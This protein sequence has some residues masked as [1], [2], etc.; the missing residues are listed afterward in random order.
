MTAW[1]MRRLLLASLTLTAAGAGAQAQ[2]VAPPSEVGVPG[3]LLTAE[4]IQNF[5]LD[6][7]YDLDDPSPG[8]TYFADT[9]LAFGLV[10][11]TPIQTFALGF[12][13][14]LRALWEAEEDFDLT[15]AS[16]STAT[17][18]YGREWASG[19]IATFLSYRQSDEDSS[20]TLIDDDVTTPGIDDLREIERDVIERRL[21]GGF[22]L[23]IA[24]DSPSSY[25]LSFA[26]S[27][28]D[29]DEEAE[30][31][32]PRTAL[33]G[34]ARWILQLNPL[35]SGVVGA[36]YSYYDAENPE[37]T[38]IREGQVDFG[39]IYTPSDILEVNVGLGYATYKR[40][41]LQDGSRETLD[42]DSGYVLLGGV[43]YLFEDI[44]LNADLRL[45]NAAPETRLSGEVR[46]VYPLPRGLV[47]GRVF[48]RYGG[49][50]TGEEVRVTG[51][52]I[53]LDREINELSALGF[54]L[55]LAK[56]E[57]LDTDEPDVERLEFTAAYSYALT[58]VVTASLGYRFRAR[59]EDP[60]EATGNAVFVEIG[61]T[62]ETRP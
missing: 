36:A 14:G 59:N 40:E 41:E 37:E 27:R 46:A 9:R 55:A 58:E 62:F 47:R 2:P 4:I 33:D 32:T 45:T 51:A 48:Q 28:I 35:I 25:E 56:Q 12:D 21:D 44:T 13:T 3:S 22:G 26:G 17:L 20:E 16:P 43:E 52:T 24:T 30:D 60:E 15:V 54:D 34:D 19:E 57:N 11:A 49:G 7:N 8:T 39:L 10:N 6:S 50:D 18:D 1:P 53:G 23:A 5:T 29:Y 61:R 31:L 42:D 38:Q